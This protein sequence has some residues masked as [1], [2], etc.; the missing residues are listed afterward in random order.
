[1][2]RVI[3]I[4]IGT[5][6]IKAIELENKMGHFD[7]VKCA[8]SRV[9]GNDVKEVLKKLLA[10]ARFSSRRVNVSLSGPSVIV[11]YI[12]MPS[13]RHDELRS[14]IKF[15]AEKYIPFSISESV[16]DFASLDKTSSGSQRVLL[17]AAK[18]SVVAGLLELFKGVGLEVNG[19]DVD[20]FAFLNAFQRGRVEE[21][22]DAACALINTGERFSNMNIA[23]KGNVYF[24]RD[25]LWGGSDI[26]KRIKD[27]MA[28]GLD[29]AEAM[30]KKP[31]EKREEVVAAI[32]PVLDKLASQVRMSFDYFESQ[33]GR[34]VEKVYVSGGSSYL[35]NM[36]DFLKDS[37][38]V[39][40]AMWNP[41]EGIRTSGAIEEM[42]KTPALFSVAMGLALRK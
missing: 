27:A 38:G 42:D 35:F 16:I 6:S 23:E 4:D 33:F 14:A 26:T 39:S 8:I 30:K 20:S 7:V 19:I 31:G 18:K 24:T 3:G 21:K 15:E 37:L 40:V 41:L 36:V 12:E 1:M 9:K 25:V 13:M 22:D 11:R 32:A 10:A 17:V 5:H 2:G 28:V 34:G 29:E